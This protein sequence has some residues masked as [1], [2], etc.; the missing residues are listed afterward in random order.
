MSCHFYILAF[1]YI[2]KSFLEKLRQTFLNV[3]NE[4]FQKFLPKDSE[5]VKS[6]ESFEKS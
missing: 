1:C 5:F 4:K 2:L 6:F 3:K